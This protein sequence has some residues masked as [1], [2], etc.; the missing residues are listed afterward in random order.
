VFRLEMS[1][2]E[3]LERAA[4]DAAAGMLIGA[5]ATLVDAGHKPHVAFRLACYL[6]LSERYGR[7][8]VREEFGISARLEREWRATVRRAAE[9]LGDDAAERFAALAQ[10]AGVAAY[11]GS[12]GVS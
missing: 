9:S 12:G 1:D 8:F 3:L 2:P 5:V 7:E 11:V 4:L 6:V 10:R